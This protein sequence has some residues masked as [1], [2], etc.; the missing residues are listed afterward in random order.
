MEVLSG[1]QAAAEEQSDYK[2]RLKHLEDCC[3]FSPEER[4]NL[5]PEYRIIADIWR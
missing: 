3:D 4:H 1:H 2:Q 5:Y